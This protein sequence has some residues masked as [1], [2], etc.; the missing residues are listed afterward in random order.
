[1]PDKKKMIKIL[2]L[3]KKLGKEYLLKLKWYKIVARYFFK[4]F[5]ITYS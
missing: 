5:R 4:S 1:M 3:E 2:K